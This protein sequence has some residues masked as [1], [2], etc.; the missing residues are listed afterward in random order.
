[1]FVKNKVD[2]FGRVLEGPQEWAKWG[3]TN[4]VILPLGMESF[5]SDKSC[6]WTLWGMTVRFMSFKI[7]TD[8]WWGVRTKSYN[9]SQTPHCLL[10][11]PCTQATRAAALVLH[12]HSYTGQY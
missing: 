5:P 11:V 3:S 12:E 4:E 6:Y 8:P 10:H 9:L 7:N 1:M 2:G